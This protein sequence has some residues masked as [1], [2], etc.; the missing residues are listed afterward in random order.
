M[1]SSYENQDSERVKRIRAYD[2]TKLAHTMYAVHTSNRLQDDIR[3]APM[4]Y[5]LVAIDL[6]ANDAHLS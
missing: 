4:M 2:I 5:H 1:P 3:I 6:H